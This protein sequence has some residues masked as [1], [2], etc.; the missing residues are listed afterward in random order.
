[1]VVLFYLYAI[2]G[3]EIFHSNV[4]DIQDSPWESGKYGDFSSFT[5]ALIALFQI[6]TQSGWHYV[7][8]YYTGGYNTFGVI[9]F[10]T[11]F[12][13]IQV[14]IFLNLTVGLIWEVFQVTAREKVEEAK[15]NEEINASK[16]EER[17]RKK[18]ERKEKKEKEGGFD[19]PVLLEGSNSKSW[20]IDNECEEDNEDED[21][22]NCKNIYI[23]IYYVVDLQNIV[24]AK[25]YLRKALMNTKDDADKIQVNI[26][27]NPAL[28]K[29]SR[30]Y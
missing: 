29:R 28:G 7:M 3:I 6:L 22:Q 15:R 20:D 14:I 21:E 17:E 27:N 13:A 11:S 24:G 2:V 26:R 1:M 5:M 4:V 25:Y 19:T 12:H 9:L 18:R 16:Q 30:I 10:F 23:Y 8:L